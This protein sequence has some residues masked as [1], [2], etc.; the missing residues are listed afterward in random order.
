MN[1]Y[2]LLK[3]AVIGLT[4]ISRT[5]SAASFLKPEL[6]TFTQYFE[7][8]KQVLIQAG[9]ACWNYELAQQPQPN[10]TCQETPEGILIN[11][12]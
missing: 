11:Y 8:T 7:P 12:E 3:Y 6:R 1:K 2:Q 5:A 4:T 9:N 10:I